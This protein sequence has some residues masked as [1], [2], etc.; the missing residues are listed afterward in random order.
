MCTHVIGILHGNDELNLW[1]VQAW[2]EVMARDGLFTPQ[3]A[4]HQIGP[5]VYV[6]AVQQQQSNNE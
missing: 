6:S 5:A 1:T 3:H 4:L 2:N